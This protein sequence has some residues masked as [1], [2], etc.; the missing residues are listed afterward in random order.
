MVAI[1]STFLAGVRCP[2]S[3]VVL[4]S[5]GDGEKLKIKVR[6][7]DFVVREKLDLPLAPD[8]RHRVY[9]LHKRG[10]NT[11]D[12][13]AAIARASGVPVSQVRYAG[14]KDRHALTAQHVSVP[15]MYS[16]STH[17]PG[18]PPGDLWTEQ[19]GF[20]DDFVSTRS[21]GGNEFEVT[22][23]SL[24]PDE[25]ASLAGRAGEV[26][27]AGFPNYFDDQRFGSVPPGGEFLGERVLKGH[28]KGAL[29]LY[30]TAEYPGLQAA[31]KERRRDI[32]GSWG[33][34]GEVARHCRGLVEKRIIEVLQRGGNKKNLLVAINTIPR[35]E[36]ALHFAAFQASVWNDVLRA[37]L[38]PVS[39]RS[40]LI[41]GKAGPYVMPVGVGEQTQ[42][43]LWAELRETNI[44]T[45]AR[46]ILPCSSAVNRAIEAALSARR[47]MA[48]DLSL[49]GIRAA[50]LKSFYRA[51]AVVPEGLRMGDPVPDDLYRGRLKARLSFAL[52]PGSYATMLLKALCG[53]LQ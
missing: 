22:V 25:A 19:L 46:R 30:L 52:P 27:E 28:L 39:G 33:D 38:K 15:R 5:V 2:A 45:V 1:L 31:E 41:P 34:W 12:A 47:L 10:W 17:V 49:R 26:R 8:G 51:A 13:I 7:E 9:A 43:G 18:V 36:M 53:L 23:R 37:L 40:I 11:L 44:P 48:S 6:P 4:I 16:L 35:D 21:L 29:R 50:Y 24:A 20:A 3:P 14:L 42:G 32:S